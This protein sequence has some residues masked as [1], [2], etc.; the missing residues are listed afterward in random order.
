MPGDV[1]RGRAARFKFFS[2]ASVMCSHRADSRCKSCWHGCRPLV[3]EVSIPGHHRKSTD[4]LFI[5][6]LIRTRHKHPV[7]IVF[8]SAS[9]RERPPC[10]SG[11]LER[12]GMPLQAHPVRGG[13]A[14]N[15]VVRSATC[16][17]FSVFNTWET[18]AAGA[19]L[20]RGTAA[21]LFSSLAIGTATVHHRAHM[22]AAAKVHADLLRDFPAV[23]ERAK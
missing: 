7:H 4:C 11:L 8:H 12:H 10:C 3:G 17:L 6:T 19:R 16:C 20:P 23:A 5:A 1:D 21:S 18:S 15:I 13:M 9:C 14:S 22:I 2:A